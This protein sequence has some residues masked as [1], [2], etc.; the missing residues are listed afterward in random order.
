VL[1]PYGL[2]GGSVASAGRAV[3]TDLQGKEHVITGKATAKLKKG[4]RIR[5]ETPGGGGWGR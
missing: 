2:Q 4:E 3:I 5:V 1:A